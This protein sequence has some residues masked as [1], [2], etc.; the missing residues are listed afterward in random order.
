MPKAWTSPRNHSR[1]RGGSEPIRT[2]CPSLL[3]VPK[4]PL[5]GAA[6]ASGATRSSGAFLF[7]LPNGFADSREAL[8]IRFTA[9]EVRWQT[10]LRRKSSVDGD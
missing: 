5:G 10:A 2:I 4:P 6:G 1:I 3:A 7:N 8:D 9:K